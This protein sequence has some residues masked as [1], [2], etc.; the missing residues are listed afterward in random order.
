MSRANARVD[1]FIKFRTELVRLSREDTLPQA[2]AFGDNDANRTNRTQLNTEIAALAASNDARIERLNKEIADFYHNRLLLLVALTI[3]GVAASFLL[4]ILFTTRFITQPVTRITRAMMRLAR[5]DTAGEVPATERKDE[6]GEMAQAVHFFQ[7]QAVAANSLTER[8]TE[9]VGR[10]AVAATQ[11]S[12]AV[13]QV[14]DGAHVQ[15]GSLQKTSLAVKQST[16]AISDVAKNTQLASGQARQAAQLVT[17]GLERMNG[18][19]DIVNAIA[20]SSSK[21]RH[22]AE[23]ISRIASQTNIL[24]LNAAIEAARAGEHGSGFAV[25]AEEVRKL[26]ENS[27]SLAQEISDIVNRAST[28]AGNGVSV[29]GEV[30]EKMQQIAQTVRE[31]DKLAGSIATAMEEQQAAV[32]EINASLTELTRIGQS[33]A[34]AAEEITATMV[35]LSKLADHTRGEVDKFRKAAE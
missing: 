8:V 28:Q 25:V 3:A 29:A 7:S 34:T 18:M 9:D 1:E 32:S 22:I 11:A 21:V 23:S 5:G 2:R 24:S 35:D 31:T 33:N 20:D 6:I 4:A 26:A 13:S 17:A 19:V 27:A 12:N 14:S 30:R 15:L 16:Q 10:I